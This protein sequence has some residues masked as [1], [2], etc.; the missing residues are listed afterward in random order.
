MSG[1]LRESCVRTDRV[2]GL[3]TQGSCRVRLGLNL[4]VLNSSVSYLLDV[5]G[6]ESGIVGG[7]DRR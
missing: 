2:Q 1:D 5:G 7:K 4:C 6:K 3:R